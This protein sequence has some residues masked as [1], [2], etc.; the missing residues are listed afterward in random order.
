MDATSDD[1]SGD[2]YLLGYYTTWACNSNYN[3]DCMITKYSETADFIWFRGMGISP[4]Y[5]DYCYK[6][7]MSIDR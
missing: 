5:T 3:P 4:S 2:I 1:N 7:E 6:I